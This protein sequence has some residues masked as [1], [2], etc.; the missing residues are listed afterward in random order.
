[1]EF[2]TAKPIFKT[3]LAASVVLKIGLAVRFALNSSYIELFI[4]YL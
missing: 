2:V 4:C 3:T 1:M